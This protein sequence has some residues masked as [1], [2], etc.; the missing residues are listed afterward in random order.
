MREAASQAA[1]GFTRLP[2]RDGEL[3]CAALACGSA[4]PSLCWELLL[5]TL[6]HRQKHRLRMHQLKI[7]LLLTAASLHQLKVL[8]KRQLLRHLLQKHLPVVVAVV[9]NFQLLRRD[10]PHGF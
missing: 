9:V 2:G 1:D 8:E 5:L 10:Q 7:T 3:R 4:A 6:L